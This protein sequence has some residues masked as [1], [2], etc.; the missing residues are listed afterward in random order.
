MGITGTEVSKEAAKV[1][2]M[3]DNFATIV[4]GKKSSF[5]NFQLDTNYVY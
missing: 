5:A 1:I 2:I 3:D 4:S